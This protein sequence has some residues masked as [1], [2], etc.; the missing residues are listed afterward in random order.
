MSM[1]MS[2]LMRRCLVTLGC[3]ALLITAHLRGDS[4]QPGAQ[5]AAKIWCAA[6]QDRTT[7]S[8]KPMSRAWRIVSSDAKRAVMVMVAEV[9]DVASMLTAISVGSRPSLEK[10]KVKLCGAATSWIVHRP[11]MSQCSVDTVSSTAPPGRRS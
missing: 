1:P 11:R 10:V 3:V 2:A 6:V 7:P 9:S 4:T 5:Q 8:T